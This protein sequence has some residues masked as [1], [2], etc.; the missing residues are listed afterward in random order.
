VHYAEQRIMSTW[1][2]NALWGKD[3]ALIKS[4]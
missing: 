2:R 3:F 4:A 1:A